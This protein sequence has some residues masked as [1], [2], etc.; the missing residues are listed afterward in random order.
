M[1]RS[2]LAVRVL[3]L[4]VTVLASTVMVEAQFRASLR[5]TVTDSSG[6][7]VPGA[8]VT[9]VNKDTN[10]TMTSVSD[11]SG[12]YIFNALAPAPYKISVERQGFQKKTLE[13]VQIIPE[14]LNSL[15]LEIAV[16]GTTTQS[17]DVTDAVQALDT[18]TAT[19][20]STISSN[21]IQH[22]PSFNRDVFQLAQLTPG[23]NGDS[24]QQSGGGS[25]ALPGT[26]GPGG[27]SGSA[28]IFQT[29]NGP[30]IQAA[31]GQYETN[32]ISVDGIST[33]SAV[34]G[35]TSIITP[36]EDSVQDMKVVSNNY[37]AE[38][39]RFSGAQIQVTSKSGTNQL[40]GS[41]FF[42]ASRPGLN[43]YQRWNGTGSDVSVDPVTG[44]KLTPSQRGLNRDE[45]RFNQYGGSLGGPIWKNKI[46]AFFNWETSPLQSSATSQG[47]YETSQ[48]DQLVGATG[49]IAGKYLSVPGAGVNA[50]GIIA[51]SC[52][53]IGLTEGTNCRTVAGGLDVGSPLTT[54]IGKQDLTYGGTPNNPGVGGGLDGIP[55][56]AFFNAVDPTK[57]SQM[58]FNGR[59]D[60]NLTGKDRL[61]FAIY[62]VPVTQTSYNGPV[63]AQ[64]LW[65][66]DAVNNAF[67]LI[68]DHTFSPTLLNQARANAAGW[69]WNEAATNPQAPF[70]LPQ[71]NFGTPNDNA[72][73]GSACAYGSAPLNFIGAPGPSILD[74]WT[75]TYSDVL[76]KVLGRHN[77][78]V[79][80]DLTR[81]YYLNENIYG[82]RP[83]Y[84]FH[85]IWDFAND[86]PFYENG[87]FDAATGLLSPNRQDDRQNL[88]GAFV[89]DDFKLRPN[90]T[91][92]LGLRWSYFG[93]LYT[94]Q[95]NLDVLQ[96]GQG[97]AALTDMSIRVGGNLATPQKT[98]F[99]PMIGF[100]YSPGNFDN[101][102]VFRGGFGIAYNQNEIAITASSF[103]N[104]PN[105]V[106][107][108]FNCSYPYTAD[109]TC[110]GTGILYQTAASI[111][112]IFGYAPNPA[113]IT[114]FGANNLPTSGVQNVT[115]FPQD[116]KS[117]TTYHYSLDMQYQLPFSSVMSIGYIGNQTRHLLRQFNYNVPAALAGA[118]LNPLFNR[119]G[120]WDNGAN[121]NYNGMI[122]SL[123]HNFSHSFQLAAQYTWSKAMDENSGPYFEDPYPYDVHAAYG[124]SDF[125]VTDAFKIWGMW[126][127]VFFKGSHSWAEKIIGGWSLS[128]IWNLHTGFPW[129]PVYNTQG[130]YYQGSDYGSLRPSSVS[131]TYGNSTSNMAFMQSTNPNFGGNGTNYF[132]APSY[133]LGPAFP[134]FAPAPSAGIQRNSLNGPGYNDLDASLSKGFGLPNNRILGEGARLEIRADVYNLFN[135][136]NLNVQQ[137]DNNLG[138]VAP[139]GTVSPNSDFGVIR[140][141]LGSRTI[142]LQARF[143]F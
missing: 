100:A 115:G 6:A 13:N 105:V 34:W 119:V 86:A 2:S 49:T 31:G 38:Y 74:Q 3:L 1:K 53:S 40:H 103:G 93:T 132:G 94:K 61:A 102:L 24:S 15:N 68:W 99:G 117:I 97:A 60:A 113:A 133:V 14:Q 139:D 65:H 141:A 143:S 5:G 56:I 57:T 92:N 136:L 108:S 50:N 118:T 59:V 10:Q 63:R 73:S 71:A 87:Q 72:C 28:G 95:N 81:L 66:H 111:N 75:Y 135:K 64:N 129:N 91:I 48:F 35:G 77:V 27:T 37:D 46:F 85:N 20:S 43:A 116:Q 47:W 78:K 140:Q 122:A 36:S 30:Q 4:I 23:V 101:K 112:S 109:P 22:M 83:G 17:V 114:A 52:A 70:G 62:W 54:G 25:Y 69:R 128:G 106:N 29:E 12:I 39:G 21:Q 19:V 142:Q 96:L 26:Q 80:G 45:N 90:L 127:P 82:A 137:I 104:P 16:G 130:V 89:Q 32:S 110:S 8:T 123:N 124:R 18:E 107:K 88:W 55:D 98:N 121:S 125:N 42:K 44:A 76:T 79:G 9:L 7:V 67:S 126:Q 33:V 134:G 131:A 84:N 41:A 11:D 120:Y 58:Q 51:Q 138:S